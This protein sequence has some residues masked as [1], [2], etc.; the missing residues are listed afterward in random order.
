MSTP[1]LAGLLVAVAA[2]SLSFAFGTPDIMG[3]VSGVAL[4]GWAVF[5]ARDWVRRRR[6]V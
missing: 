2:I 1:T 5:A 6:A 4:V 3:V